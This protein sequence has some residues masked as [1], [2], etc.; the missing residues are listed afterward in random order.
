MSSRLIIDIGSNTIKC[1]LA[2]KRDNE[3]FELWSSTENSRISDGKGGLVKDSAT[4]IASCVSKFCEEAKLYS[5]DFKCT[6]VATSAMREFEKSKEITDLVYLKTGVKINI[7][8]ET[9]EAKLSYLGAMT[10]LNIPRVENSVFFDLGGGSMEFVFGKNSLPV[11]WASFPIGAVILTKLY[12]N[13]G[14]SVTQKELEEMASDCNSNFDGFSYL[15]FPHS[16][17]LLF[18]TGGALSAARKISATIT[19]K[20]SP[21]IK[22]SLLTEILKEIAPMDVKTRAD[23]FS[24]DISRA[25]IL[26]AAFVCIIEATKRFGVDEIYHTYR[27]LRY[28][29][30]EADFY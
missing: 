27:N 21:I 5:D 18:G 6:A 30:L 11:N 3:I 28:G 2:Q 14:N 25:D 20:D 15:G 1:L 12:S 7:I 10:D 4:M 16:C 9:E 23:R 19:K 8:S 29:V 26:P 24:I 13:C 17:N 22:L